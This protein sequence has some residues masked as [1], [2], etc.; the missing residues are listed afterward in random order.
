MSLRPGP[1]VGA[2]GAIFG[3]TASV[4]VVLYRYHSRFYLRDKRIGFVLAVWAG[5]QV[6]SGFAS[7]YI[8]NFGH[9]GG[10][11]GGALATLAVRPRLLSEG[12]KGTLQ[13]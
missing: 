8:D 9:L 13:L 6:L 1:S 5:Y 7:P 12:E 2:S 11:A 4:V 3:L 10:L